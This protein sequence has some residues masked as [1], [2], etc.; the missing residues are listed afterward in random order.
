MSGKQPHPTWVVAAGLAWAL[1][2]PTGCD[3]HDRHA[4]PE[5]PASVAPETVTVEPR[6]QLLPTFPCSSKCHAARAPQPEKRLLTEFHT[7][8]NAEFHHGDP[9]GWCYQCHSQENIDRL[10]IASGELVTFDEA[11]LLCGGCHGDKLR[12]W[13]LAVHGKTMGHWTG[14]K[15]RRSCTGCHNPHNPTFP[16]LVPEA[17]PV[18]PEHGER[19]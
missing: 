5:P 16:H 15:I 19:M 10:V 18:S 6:T 17:P 1:G 12:D 13:R 3:E 9:A 4:Y 11:Y 8:R 14:N 7:F 2:A